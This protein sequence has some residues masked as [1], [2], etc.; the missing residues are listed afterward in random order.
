MGLDSNQLRDR[1]KSPSNKSSISK[2]TKH[3]GR[4]RFHTEVKVDPLD[5]SGRA[6]S[7][8]LAYVEKLLPLEKY[9]NFLAMFRMPV[10]TNEVVEQINDSLKKVFDGRDPYSDFSFESDEVKQDWLA[11]QQSNLGGDSKWEHESFEVFRMAIN[12]IMIVDLPKLSVNKNGEVEQDSHRPEPYYYFKRIESIH[13][14]TV[15]QKGEIV[16][17]LYIV[18]KVDENGKK[19]DYLYVYDDQS[20]RVFK[21]DDKKQI[22]DEAIVDTAHDLGYCP[23]KFFWSQVINYQDTILKQ[24][25]LSNQLS[26]L[27]DLLFDMIGKANLDLYA[28]YPIYYGIEVDCDYKHPENSEYCEGG[29][30]KSKEGH[31][32]ID[33]NGGVSRCPVCSSQ[34]FNGAG[35]YVEYPA[36]T[37]DDPSY[38]VPVGVVPTDKGSLEYNRDEVI[39]KARE[40][41]NNVV[42]VGVDIPNQAVNDLQVAASF[43]SRKAVIFNLK[44][45]FEV[46]KQWR[47]QTI[48]LL[49]YGS[50]LFKGN[51]ENLGTEFYLESVDELIAR[52][53]SAK[54]NGSTISELDSIQDQITEMQNKNNPMALNRAKILVQL[55]PFR[56][57]TINEVL[58]K[59]QSDSTIYDHAD[60]Q[61]KVKFSNFISKFERENGSVLEF[62]TNLSFDEKINRIYQTLNSYVTRDQGDKG[63][64]GSEGN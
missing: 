51:S 64:E 4:L 21:L 20:F 45:N 26:S 1:L 48:C 11:Y 30:I 54:E 47:D 41:K 52:Y 39:R 35:T 32:H 22:T 12:S 2:A 3:E 60:V 28:K 59:Y 36:P 63:G 10:K 61:I 15:N 62:G 19:T 58:E 24:S 55:E 50:D 18:G 27:D 53:K 42:G 6:A 17:L 29:Y 16:D 37:Q 40:I 25:P 33:P 31:Y 23:C 56:H 38:G 49:R 57:Q 13:D 5:S 14:L 34:R 8:F 43:E 44:K 9:R 46:I 7:E